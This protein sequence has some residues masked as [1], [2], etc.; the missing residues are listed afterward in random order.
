MKKSFLTLILVLASS[1]IFA[2]N[3]SDISRISNGDH[4]FAKGA[5]LVSLADTVSPEFIEY[6]F[7]RFGYE[8]LKADIHPISGYFSTNLYQSKMTELSSHPYIK[9]ILIRD[10]GFNEKAFLEMVKRQNMSSE[11]SAR[12]RKSLESMAANPIKH[13]LFNHYVTKEMATTFSQTLTEIG[14]KINMSVPK[15]VIIKTIPGKEQEA[16]KAVSLLLYVENTAF[17]MLENEQ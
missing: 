6:Q 14:M 16:M 5:I 7:E 15:S 13:V 11:D 1:S 2:Q 9:E 12:S 10:S 3:Q 8:I 17:V 4:K